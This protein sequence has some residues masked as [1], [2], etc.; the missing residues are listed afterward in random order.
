[1]V[2]DWKKIKH[3]KPSEFSEPNKMEPLLIHCLD[4]LREI[5][6]QPIIVHSSYR[7]GDTGTHGRGEAVDI[8]IKGLNVVEQFLIAEKTRLFSGIGVYPFWNNPGLHL[9]VRELKAHEIGKRWARN[10][11]GIYVALDSKFLLQCKI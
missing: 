7:V 2:I 10:A 5:V 6:K 3:F 8:H 9:D 4:R 1:M 11:R